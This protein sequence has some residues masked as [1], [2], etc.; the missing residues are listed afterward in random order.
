VLDLRIGSVGKT[1]E[2]PA[3]IAP[4]LRR[5]AK[6]QRAIVHPAVTPGAHRQSFDRRARGNG[7]MYAPVVLGGQRQD[8]GAQCD[9]LLYELESL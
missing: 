4:L 7:E 5:A 2:K 8:V 6:A 3:A 9:G 1:Q